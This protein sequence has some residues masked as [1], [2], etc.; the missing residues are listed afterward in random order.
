MTVR[1]KAQ[2][3]PPASPYTDTNGAASFLLNSAQTMAN[4]RLKGGGPPFSKIG[5]KVIYAVSDLLAFIEA[6]KVTSTSQLEYRGRKRGR[7]PTPKPAPIRASTLAPLPHERALDH[8][9]LPNP[10]Q[11]P[12]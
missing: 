6:R 7:P 4:W 2:P 11:N 9:P 3:T 8:Q 10:D 5:K 12:A 1:H